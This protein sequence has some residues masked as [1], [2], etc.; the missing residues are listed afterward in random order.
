MD[1]DGQSTMSGSGEMYEKFKKSGLLTK[2]SGYGEQP[3]SFYD[4][5][6][7]KASLRE[8]NLDETYYGMDYDCRSS[9]IHYNFFTYILLFHK[10]FTL[11]Y[12]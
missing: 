9:K 7:E 2:F 10:C 12:S 11:N 4:P 1:V 6:F 3:A 8:M 5:N